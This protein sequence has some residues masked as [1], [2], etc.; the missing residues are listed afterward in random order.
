MLQG[1]V[2]VPLSPKVRKRQSRTR[3]R[4]LEQS[5][6]LFIAKGFEN[7]SVEEIIDAAEIARSSFYR[8]FSNREQVLANIIRPVFDRG[9]AEL[10]KINT[11][12]PADTMSGIFDTYLKLWNTS[13]DALRISTR[14]GGAYFYLFADVHAIFRSKLAS[15]LD[16]IEPSGI[17][18]ND[19]AEHTGRL[20]ART[21][22]HVLEVYSRENDFAELFHKTMT[23]YLLN[24][25]QR[26]RVRNQ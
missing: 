19:S 26:S 11:A 20:L 2:A 14:V 23:G 4:I 18:I 16:S 17:F 8:F 10:E 5:A 15:L 25:G 21:A 13:P 3:Q 7:V 1:N 12:D 9:V 6:H 22:V 24:T